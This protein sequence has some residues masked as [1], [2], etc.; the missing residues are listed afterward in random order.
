MKISVLVKIKEPLYQLE[1]D[2]HISCR[3]VK[4]GSF[5]NYGSMPEN[6]NVCYFMIM[7]T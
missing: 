4:E 2:N 1:N 6:Q 5:I 3:Y 7:L